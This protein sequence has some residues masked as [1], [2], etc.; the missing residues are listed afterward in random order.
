[1]IASVV[2]AASGWPLKQLA[3][4]RG[5]EMT[6]VL[7]GGEDDNAEWNKERLEV[8]LCIGLWTLSEVNGHWRL[9]CSVVVGF[10]ILGSDVLVAA[11]VSMGVMGVGRS[12]SSGGE[13]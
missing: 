2:R 12:C 11:V 1:M 8:G 7:R 5:E 4:V 3:A 9:R 13:Q 10:E 6:T